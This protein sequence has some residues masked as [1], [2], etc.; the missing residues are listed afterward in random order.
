MPGGGR[1]DQDQVGG[2]G[3]LELLHLAEHEDVL[4]ARDGGRHHVEGPRAAEAREI[5]RRPW[6]SRYSSERLVGG[7]GAG[8]HARARAPPPRRSAAAAPKHAASPDLPSTSTIS[9]LMPARAAATASAAVTV[10]FPT[11]PLPATITT[12]EVAQ[13]RSRSMATDATGVPSTAPSAAS[14]VHVPRSRSRASRSRSTRPRRAAEHAGRPERDRRRAGRG[15]LRPAQRVA[16]PRRDPARR[17][18][19]R[20]TLLVLQVTRRARSTPTSTTSCA[21]SSGR[22]CRSR[23]G[24]GRRAPTPRAR[25]R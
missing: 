21:R 17:T 4:H 15:L 2:A 22:A 24:S 23:C 14:R 19:T 8:P 6:S 13:K 20:S 9:T 16:R 11:P 18:T 3:P 10:V 1:V 12:R 5:R 7:E 25:P